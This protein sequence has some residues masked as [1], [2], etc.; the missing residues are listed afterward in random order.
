M[1][2]A[3]WSIKKDVITWVITFV[4]VVVGALSFS[5]LSRLEDP[6]FTIKQAIVLTPYPGATPAEVEEEVTNV[7]E[8]AVQELGEVDWIESQSTRGFSMV[9]INITTTVP[10][11]AIPQLW[12]ELRRKINDYQSQLPPGA[13]PSLVNDDFG[14]VYGIYL[15]ITGDGYTD[16]ELH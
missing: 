3:E 13:G 7:I 14:D 1:N 9:K 11:E 8:M 15:A 10:K 2:I 16:M 5:G 6:K 12:D 4:L